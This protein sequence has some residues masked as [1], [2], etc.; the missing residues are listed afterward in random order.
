M[1]R[2]V[3]KTLQLNYYCIETILKFMIRDPKYKLW[4]IWL[5][6][7]DVLKFVDFDNIILYFLS[8]DL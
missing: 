2:N 4:T 1:K 6:L 8:Y 3:V 5:V 7:F